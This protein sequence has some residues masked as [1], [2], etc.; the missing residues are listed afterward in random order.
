MLLLILI[1]YFLYKSDNIYFLV[2]KLS[3]KKTFSLH[4]IKAFF[5]LSKLK[6][7]FIRLIKTIDS[8][9]TIIIIILMKYFLYKSDNY[10]YFLVNELFKNIF[11][12]GIKVF[13]F[14]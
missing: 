6:L 3:F 11:L 12:H 4:G 9:I 8:I 2:N 10:I 1:K 13:L 14:K 7:P 5:Y